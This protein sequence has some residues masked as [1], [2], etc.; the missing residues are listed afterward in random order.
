MA[1]FSTSELLQRP[2]D[3][4]AEA[5]RGP[6]TLTEQ[7][8]PQLVLLSIDDFRRLRARADCRVAQRTED[9]SDG[10]WAEVAAAIEAYERE[11]E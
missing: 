11:G 4:F 7:D 6:V 5:A 9:M 10:L 2:T 3:V 8:E 1:S